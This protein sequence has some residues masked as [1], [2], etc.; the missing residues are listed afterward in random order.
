M[1]AYFKDRSERMVIYKEAAT[2]LREDMSIMDMIVNAL[3]PKGIIKYFLE[4]VSGPQS[5]KLARM[6]TINA[7]QYDEKHLDSMFS[8]I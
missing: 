8:K 6:Q 2:D 3:R 7:K 5:D 4:G 1:T